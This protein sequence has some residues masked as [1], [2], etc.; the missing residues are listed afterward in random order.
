MANGVIRPRKDGQGCSMCN[1]LPQNVGKKKCCHTLSGPTF[2]V[3][4][5]GSTKFI[6]ISGTDEKTNKDISLSAKVSKKQ[7][8]NL[9]SQFQ[10]LIETKDISD[11]DKKAIKKQA[12]NL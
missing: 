6:D 12:R 11:K 8:E 2:A 7:I 10:G 3:R 5:E 4:K 9:I 1:A